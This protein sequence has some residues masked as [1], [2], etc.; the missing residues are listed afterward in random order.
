MGRRRYTEQQFR[1]AVADPTVTTIAELCRRL[2]IVP[3]GG[4]YASL[5]GLGHDTGIGIDAVLD[6][7][8]TRRWPGQWKRPWTAGDLVDALGREDVNS[9]RSLCAALG[10]QPR[11]RS[12]RR[13]RDIAAAQSLDL[14]H[15]VPPPTGRLPRGLAVPD[16][17]IRHAVAQ[18]G[19]RDE[20]LAA[21]GVPVTRNSRRHL[22][23][24]IDRLE[25]P[26]DHLAKSRAADGGN[27][28][29]GGRPRRP[30]HEL[31]RPE[32]DTTTS[33]VR[34]R[35]A[36]E[37]I[38]PLRCQQCGRAW[39]GE[40]RIPLELDHADGDRRNNRIDNLRLV[41]PNCHALTLTYRG[42][43]IGRRLGSRVEA[44]TRG[45]A[46]TGDTGTA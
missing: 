25:I 23:A 19:T 41:C 6:A 43:N 32:T 34:R 8:T 46:G 7:R 40:Q 14:S 42:R 18:A 24:A 4:N 44:E 27:H 5:R 36:Q 29:G 15:L 20:A 28:H 17:L 39:W 2:G 33:H 9:F 35:L 10:V 13:I 30:L 45:R 22:A 26:T 37:G 11:S 16:D 12:Y 21:M 1:D 31:L 38:F 3:R